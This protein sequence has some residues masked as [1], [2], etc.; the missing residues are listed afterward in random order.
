M[1]VLVSPGV[2]SREIDLSLYAPAL[3]ST[4]LGLVGT[5]TKG[6]TDVAHLITDVT[7]LA[8]VVGDPSPNH[9]AILVAQ[10]YLKFGRQLRF[11][12]VANQATLAAASANLL[13]A[14]A[15]PA[16]VT[17]SQT[18]PFAITAATPAV[19]TG[20][21]TGPFDIS[22]GVNDALKI[23]VAGV[24]G[25]ADQDVVLSQ[26]ATK[27]A[28]DV[29]NEINAQ[30]EGLVASVNGDGQIVL[31]SNDLGATASI[32]IK[33]VAND[34]YTRLGLTAA[35]T[36]GADGTNALSVA[37]G[38]VTQPTIYLTAG[39][40]RTAAQVAADIV[41]AGLTAT[42]VDNAIRLTSTA[43]GASASVQVQAAGSTAETPLGL[44]TTL[45]NGT[46]V[47]ATSVTVTAIS[48]GTWAHKVT[49]KVADSATVS[50][51]KNLSVMLNG[52][53]KEIFRNL[54]K[55]SASASYWE[56]VINGVSEYITVTDVPATT[57]QPAN[58]ATTPLTGGND[59][60]TGITD[61]DY[62]GVQGDGYVTGL[63][64]FADKAT[65]D[66]NLIAIPGQ[67]S[68]AVHSAMI[69]LVTS[70]ADSMCLVDPPLGL[71]P[72]QV[73]DFRQALG[74]YS[75]T[76]VAINSNRAAM[77]YP[78][79]KGYDTSNAVIVDLP[80]CAAAIRSY[81]YNDT[82]GELWFAPMG[83]T[84][85]LIPEAVGI[86]RK[87]RE[88]EKDY[89]Y[90]LG[91]NP[92]MSM[93]SY[94]VIIMGVKTLQVAPTSLDRVN[95]RRMMDY[96]HKVTATVTFPLIGEPNTPRLW[97]RLTAVLQP[98]L[99][100]L[101]QREGLTAYQIVCDASTNPQNL[102]NAHEVHAKIGILPT[103][104]A[105]FIYTDFVLVDTMATFQE[106]LAP[107]A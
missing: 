82:V 92:I 62:I 101:K 43:T 89:L 18:G 30:T 33:A 61:A 6:E 104:D 99:E 42:V 15:G 5:A 94:G 68:M 39:A 34:A 11:V 53:V 81:I 37:V 44:D 36:T 63:Q 17:G 49:V 97:R 70:R 9:P 51:A 76:R 20:T 16:V 83:A 79:V 45:H 41:I 31:T 60:L 87:L 75:G 1:A 93:S 100:Y 95:V 54:V 90:E 106:Y 22:T 85:G 13:T 96:L 102:V 77:Y 58:I 47:G 27:T 38:G 10:W 32:Q 2:L 3:T 14:A 67:T 57:P 23:V 35:T 52:F 12:R 21:E 73:G 98:T 19:V 80:P 84:R 69:S 56:T 24:N 105:E 72:T 74:A 4:I 103:P 86:E 59:G 28:L 107:A 91:I 8:Q 7:Q 55:D 29:A 50:G 78:W 65:I 64:E 66:I 88:G 46:A 71:T 40:A 25:D 48:K 26:N